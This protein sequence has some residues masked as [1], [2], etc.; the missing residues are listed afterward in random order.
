MGLSMSNRST[1][2]GKVGSDLDAA[3]NFGGNNDFGAKESDTIERSYASRGVRDQD[4]GGPPERATGAETRDAGV[5]GPASG[6]GCNSGGDLD[7][8]IIGVGTGGAGVSTRWQDSRAFRP[9]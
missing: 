3:R 8:D 9:G 6:P 5:G 1:N 2:S 7:T 4:P